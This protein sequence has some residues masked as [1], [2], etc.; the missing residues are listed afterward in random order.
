[1]KYDVDE[2]LRTVPSDVAAGK[3]GEYSLTDND[4]RVA[5]ALFRRYRPVRVLE[6]GVCEGHTA[7]F[8]LDNCPW[9]S[10]Y[11]GVDLMPELFPSRG[12][13][14]KQ[15]GALAISDKRFHTILTDETAYMLAREV[16]S[17]GWEYDCVIIDANHTERGTRR[18]TEAVSWALRPGGLMLWHDYGVCARQYPGSTIFGVKCYLDG[19]NE[20]GGYVNVPDRPELSSLAWEISYKPGDRCRW[21][22]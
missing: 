5:L 18:D 2:L 15:A 9:I 17:Y 20:G 22:G 12:I 10:T 11:I 3:M 4:L 1:M 7:K 13:V 6:V 8:L 21:P 14:P 19:I 16:A